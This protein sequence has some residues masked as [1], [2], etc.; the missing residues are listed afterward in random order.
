MEDQGTRT[1][2]YVELSSQS[3]GMVVDYFASA[4]Q[5][6]LD[7]TKSI[8]EIFSK[9]Y[10]STTPEAAVREGFDRAHQFV[11]LTVNELQATGQKRAELAEKVVAHAAKWQDTYTQGLRGM[12]KTGIANMSYVKDAAETSFDGFAKRVEELQAR[13]TVS[14]N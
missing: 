5:R 2:S 13:A 9:P 12:L 6:A 3:Y 1:P 8:Y 14:S 10:A 4:N 11:N 7:Y